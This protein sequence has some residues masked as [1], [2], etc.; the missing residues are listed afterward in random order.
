MFADLTKKELEKVAGAGTEVHV[1]GGTTVMTQGAVGHSALVLLSGSMVV[2][3]NGRKVQELAAGDI[4]GEMALF[5]DQPRSATVECLTDC[6][7]LEITAGQL[8]AVMTDVP[9]ITHKVLGTLAA[10]VRDLDRDVIG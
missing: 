7:V 1:P 5:D 2:R 10:R 6:A 8:R 3:R 9:A 4:V